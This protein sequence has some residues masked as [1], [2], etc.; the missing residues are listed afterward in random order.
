MGLNNFVMTFPVTYPCV[1][2]AYAYLSFAASRIIPVAVSV[3][4]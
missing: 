4:T 2:Y 3:A 1:V